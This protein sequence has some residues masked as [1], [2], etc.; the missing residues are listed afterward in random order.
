M[1][2][3]F[4]TMVL[5]NYNTLFFTSKWASSGCSCSKIIKFSDILVEVSSMVYVN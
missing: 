1:P 3:S 2:T 5:N 4:T